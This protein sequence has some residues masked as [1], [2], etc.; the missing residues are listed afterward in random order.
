MAPAGVA[1][2]VPGEPVTHHDS[3]E[4]G[5]IEVADRDAPIIRSLP[6]QLASNLFAEHERLDGCRGLAPPGSLPSGAAI[7]SNRIAILPNSIVSPSRT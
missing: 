2:T 5:A 3:L 4:I 7:P 1:R 6:G